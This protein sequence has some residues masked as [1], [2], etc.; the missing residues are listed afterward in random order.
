[1][2][3]TLSAIEHGFCCTECGLCV[4]ILHCFVTALL[5][6]FSAVFSAVFM[7]FVAIWTLS[8]AMR[9]K[10]PLARQSKNLA[11]QHI[12]NSDV[13]AASNGDDGYAEWIQIPLILMHIEFD[14]SLRETEVRFN[15]STAILN[16]PDLKR[17]PH[18]SS[19]CC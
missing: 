19:F 14:K 1:M 16:E 17:V 6:P 10:R 2:Q 15:G 9:S 13:P 5:M 7:R 11:K 4:Y 3:S 18:Y 8:C 12:D